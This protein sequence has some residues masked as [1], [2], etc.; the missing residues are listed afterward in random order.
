LSDSKKNWRSALRNEKN[1][2]QETGNE[3]RETGQRYGIFGSPVSN[4]R[5]SVSCFP[6]SIVGIEPGRFGSGVAGL[7][8]PFHVPGDLQPTTH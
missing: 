2:K 3:K 6:F 7:G 8:L 1:G 4:L 5:F